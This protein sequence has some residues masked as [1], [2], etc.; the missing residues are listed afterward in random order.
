MSLEHLLS[1]LEPVVLEEQTF[2]LQFFKMDSKVG[3]GWVCFLFT[4]IIVEKQSIFVLY[5]VATLTVLYLIPFQVSDVPLNKSGTKTKSQKQV[6]I[7][8]KK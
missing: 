3:S 5:E 2:C 6:E 8:V 7:P 4:R 1:C